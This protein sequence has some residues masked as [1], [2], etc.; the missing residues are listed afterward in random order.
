MAQWMWAG[1]GSET[2]ADAD[3]RVGGRYEVYMTPPSA[4]ANWPAPRWGFF[5]Y[6]TEV[7]APRRLGYTLHWDAPVG[8]N[9]GNARPADEVVLVEIQAA[10]EGCAVV[11]WHMGIPSID[12]AA[13]EHGRGIEAEFD[14]LEQLLAGG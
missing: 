10:D 13:A 5:G 3:V 11:R 12:G 2:Q 1:W 9:L 6:Y 4:D 14:A 8:Y 7:A